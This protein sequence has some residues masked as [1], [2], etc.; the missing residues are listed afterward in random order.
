MPQNADLVR[1]GPF[2]LEVRLAVGGTAEVYLAHPVDSRAEPRRLVVKRLLPDLLIDPEGLTMFEREARLH[3][4]VRHENVVECFGSGITEEGEPWLALEWIDGLDGYRLLR[5]L[6]GEAQ[7]M[8][9]NVAVHA[10]RELL[11]ALAS[12]HSARGEDGRPL[13]I[14]HRDISPSNVYFSKSGAV[15][16]GDFGIARDEARPLRSQASTSLKGKYAYLSPEQV[17]SEPFDQRAD[18]FSAA[19]VL[20]ECLLGEPLFSGTGQLAVLLAIRD[21][22]LDP[23]T[24]ARARF[25]HGL[26]EVLVRALGHDPN[27]RFPTAEALSNALAPFDPSPVQSR[28][29]IAQLVQAAARKESTDRMIA[30]RDSVRRVAVA[31]PVPEDEIEEERRPSERPTGEYTTKPS[32]VDAS[33]GRKFGPWTF[34]QLVEALATGLVGRGD[35]VS[36]MGAP[37][38]PVEAINALDRFLPP[39]SSVTT[40]VRGPKPQFSLDLATSSMLEALLRTIENME[41]GA[42]F[43]TDAPSGPSAPERGVGRKE[44]YFLKGRLH[45]VASSSASELLGEYLVRRGTIA[46]EEL[47]MALAVLPRN[48]GRMGDTLISLGLVEPMTLFRAIREQGRDRVADLFSWKQGRVAFY[49]GETA[50]HVEFPLDIDTVTLLLA[51]VEAALPGDAALDKW[52]GALGKKLSPGMRDRVGLTHLHWPSPLSDLITH[53]KRNARLSDIIAQLS[54]TLNIGASDLARALEILVVARLVDLV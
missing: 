53:S 41:T 12:V 50:P 6:K 23:L 29:E 39:D 45:H 49:R 3:A 18:L 17:G 33:D 14:V 15:K 9:I 5:R 32:F 42:L 24:K 27:T 40:D 4:A 47:D 36:Y 19:V 46:R 26:Y 11:Q 13:N 30:V 2:Y 21:C 54:R 7:L 8:P 1:F 38:C 37:F 48:Q 22:R 44:L 16:L 31:A 34:A 28:A 52:R 20:A 25:P 51:G 43:A 35:R 10:A